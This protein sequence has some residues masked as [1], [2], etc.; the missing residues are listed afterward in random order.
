MGIGYRF[1]GDRRDADLPQ[2][3]RLLGVGRKVKVGE[4]HL[5]LA[6]HLALTGLR[7]LHFHKDLGV[8][9]NVLGCRHNLGTRPLVVHVGEPLVLGST[10]LD[11]HIMTVG[12]RLSDRRGDHAD[13]IF[14]NLYLFRNADPHRSLPAT[15]H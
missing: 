10:R 12:H 7:L 11:E 4:K 8:G 3:L 6:Q 14:V 15:Q 1:V 2:R 13:A 5:P 9:K